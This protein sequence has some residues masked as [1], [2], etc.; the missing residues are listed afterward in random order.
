M[1]VSWLDMETPNELLHHL[2]SHFGKVN[3]SISDCVYKKSES[4]SELAS[5]LDGIPNGERQFWMNVS[6]PLPSYGIIDG[7]RVKT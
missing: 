3:S 1:N 5:F 4:D 7:K 2:F 6:T